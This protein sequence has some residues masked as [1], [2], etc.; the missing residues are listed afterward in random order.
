[1]N[2]EHNLSEEE[3]EVL[4][5]W[6][7]NKENVIFIPLSV[8]VICADCGVISNCA[9]EQCPKCPGKNMYSLAKLRRLSYFLEEIKI[10]GADSDNSKI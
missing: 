4:L 5:R 2:Q 10:K 9:T 6:H 1:M 8:A 7:K 3:K